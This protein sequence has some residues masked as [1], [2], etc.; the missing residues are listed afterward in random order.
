MKEELINQIFSET[1][2]IIGVFEILASNTINKFRILDEKTHKPSEMFPF[3]NNLVSETK[4]ICSALKDNPTEIIA[5]SADYTFLITAAKTDGSSL[6]MMLPKDGNI[7]LAKV[8]AQRIVA[9]M[10]SK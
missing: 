2:G 3:L 1:E 4:K 8:V 10:K 5:N 7:G 6:I 9:Q